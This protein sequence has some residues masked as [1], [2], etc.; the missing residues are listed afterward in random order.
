VV[1]EGWD[2]FG[3]VGWVDDDSV[4]GGFVGDEVGVVVGAADPC[5]CGLELWLYRDLDCLHMGS[6][7]ICMARI[8]FG[9]TSKVGKNGR[10][11]LE[12]IMNTLSLD[13][14]RAQLMQL[15]IFVVVLRIGSS[16]HQDD[17]RSYLI[18]RVWLRVIQEDMPYSL[19]T[20]YR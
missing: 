16:K 14:T 1:F 6:D 3:W 10:R 18:F 7:W 12:A 11:S 5:V 13:S 2:N 20:E 19:E 15:V 4:F 9:R 17:V 8:V